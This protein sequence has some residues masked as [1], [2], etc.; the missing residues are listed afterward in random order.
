MFIHDYQSEIAATSDWDFE[1]GATFSSYTP[2]AVKQYG[3]TNISHDVEPTPTP[4]PVITP[5]TPQGEPRNDEPLITYNE[6]ESVD[7]SE[8]SDSTAGALLF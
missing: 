6:E 1:N 2:A 3:T 4:Q 5:P 7:F 8:S